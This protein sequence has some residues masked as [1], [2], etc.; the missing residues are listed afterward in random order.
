MAAR[1]VPVRWNTAPHCP[2]AVEH[3]SWRQIVGLQRLRIPDTPV[4]P[5]QASISLDLSETRGTEVSVGLTVSANSL[6]LKQ[7]TIG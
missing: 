3:G 6:D 5:H 7:P 2:S 1:T 4:H